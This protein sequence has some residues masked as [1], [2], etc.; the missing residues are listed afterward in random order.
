[1]A[2][3]IATQIKLQ[4]PGGQATPAAQVEVRPLTV[5]GGFLHFP[6]RTVVGPP[7]T[8]NP[9]GPLFKFAPGSPRDH[10]VPQYGGWRRPARSPDGVKEPPPHWRAAMKTIE[11]GA[12]SDGTSLD[13]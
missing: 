13:A 2:K 6:P 1:M 7:V 5:T 8:L 3:Q 10:L 12:A 9:G 4:A 11:A